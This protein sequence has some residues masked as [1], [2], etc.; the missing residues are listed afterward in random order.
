MTKIPRNSVLKIPCLLISFVFY[1]GLI[2][3]LQSCSQTPEE[4]YIEILISNLKQEGTPGKLSITYPSDGTIFPPEIVPP[5]FIWDETDQRA[6]KWLVIVDF[7]NENGRITVFTEKKIWRPTSGQWEIIKKNSIEKDIQITVLGNN[8]DEPEKIVSGSSITVR[9]S[10]DQVGAPVFFRAVTLPFEFTVNNLH[11]VSWR[12]GNIASESQPTAVL[13]DLP[14]CGNCHS[15][16][17]DGNTL[18]MDVDYANDK[19]S[20]VITNFTKETILSQDKIITWSDYKRDEK[21][22]TFGLLSQI[23]PDG[24]YVLS[25]VKDRSIFVPKNDLNYSQLFFPIKGIIAVY[26]R[27]TQKFWSLPGADDPKYVQSNA[28]WSPDGKYVIFARAPYRKHK[29][30][31]S[32]NQVVLPTDV[33]ADYIEG[34]RSFQY[35]LFRIPFNEGRGGNPEPLPGASNNGK[36][37]YFAKYSPDGKWIVFTQAQNFM[38]LQ[39]DSRLFIL[40]TQGGKPREMTCNTSNMNSWHSWSPNG[41]WLVFSSKERGP[42]TQLYLTHIDEDGNDSPPVLLENF[43]IP[44]RGA[45]I[46]EFVNINPDQEINLIENFLYSGNYFLRIGYFKLETG[47][48]EEALKALDKA[49]LQSPEEPLAFVYRG[50]VKERLGDITGAI[51]DCNQAIRVDPENVLAYNNRGIIHTS[52]KNYEEAMDDF[53]K[54]I[55]LDPECYEAYVN[56]GIIKAYQ[57]FSREAID[58]FNTAIKINPDNEM[59]YSR[60]KTVEENMSKNPLRTP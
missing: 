19:G 14:V 56:R 39:P 30:V 15:F 10:K 44:D 8:S 41:K 60:K 4:K 21:E 26:D 24:R 9:T 3:L 37:N 5:T 11:T 17:S 40:S 51:K 53:N 18:A 47:N 34:K 49:I 6:N 22:Y 43:I 50:Q 57:G 25:T 16:S 45:N 33:A 23:S 54:A 28:S 32:S 46:P 42:F 1:I 48:L 20:Y 7:N 36:S 38:L 35:D 13:T 52:L 55:S 2:C 31:E 59:A 29:L 12:L 58:D 27:E